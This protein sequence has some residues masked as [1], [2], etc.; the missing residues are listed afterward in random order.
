MQIQHRRCRP[1]F[2]PILPSK[3]SIVRLKRTK[4][5]TF[6]SLVVNPAKYWF[7]GSNLFDN[8]VWLWKMEKLQNR[9]KVTGLGYVEQNTY[10]LR[11]SSIIL[12][13][14]E[15]AI[16]LCSNKYIYKHIFILSL[17]TTTYIVEYCRMIKLGFENV[18][19]IMTILVSVIVKSYLNI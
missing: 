2:Q 1:H 5:R 11:G 19:Y 14:R 16:I 4:A 17:N 3:N 18:Q 12:P 10:V 13:I 6:E 7:G 9:L 15:F 8:L